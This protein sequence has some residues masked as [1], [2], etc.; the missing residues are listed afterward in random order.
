LS[1]T[2]IVTQSNGAEEELNAQLD[3]TLLECA[4]TAGLDGFVGE[5]GGNCACGTCHC[6]VEF[7]PQGALVDP[8][9]EELQMLDFV[10]APR[11]ENS[12]LACQIRI[13]EDMHGM[14]ITMPERQF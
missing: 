6:Y 1:I 12:R 5:C 10:A 14:K 4:Q 3:Q 7:A 13:T 11:E 2:I 8:T 9:N